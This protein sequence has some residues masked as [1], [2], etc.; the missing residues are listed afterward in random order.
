MSMLISSLVN[1]SWSRV[2]IK[3]LAKISTLILLL[4][5]TCNLA[6]ARVIM[7]FQP[8]INEN[9]SLLSDV[10]LLV[11]PKQGLCDLSDLS[12][13][14]RPVFGEIINNNQVIDWV[15]R[16]T[17]CEDVSILWLGKVNAT[18]EGKIK[19]SVE[20]LN[21]LAY[22]ALYNKLKCCYKNFSIK[23]LSQLTPS[24]IALEKFT[25][26]NQSKIAPRM[27]VWLDSPQQS[28]PV[29]FK[30]KVLEPVLTARKTLDAKTILDEKN[31]I[32]ATRDITLLNQPLTKIK[33]GYRLKRRLEKNLSLSLLYIEPIPEVLAGNIVNVSHKHQSTTDCEKAIALGDGYVNSIIWIKFAKINKRYPAKVLAKNHVEL[34]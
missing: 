5:L 34:E 23:Q 26:H 22:K 29:W 16:Q 8:Q 11:N 24:G 32:L 19:S 18:V 25:P 13:S 21:Q 33:P 28:I 30:V 7:R 9:A 15:H 27:R 14:S 2:L 1:V 31:F 4:V 3:C 17:N 20:Q 6:Q 12:L 10:V